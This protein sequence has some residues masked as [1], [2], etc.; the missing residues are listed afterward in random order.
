[1]AKPEKELLNVCNHTEQTDG[2]TS[3]EMYNKM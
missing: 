1:M 3:R 2:E